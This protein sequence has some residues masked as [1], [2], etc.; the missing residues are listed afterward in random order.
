MHLYIWSYIHEWIVEIS[1]VKSVQTQAQSANFWLGPTFWEFDK[2]QQRANECARMSTL[3]SQLHQV[4]LWRVHDT[5]LGHIC[6]L[7]VQESSS[8]LGQDLQTPQM[9]GGRD[10]SI[11][12][13][14]KIF[15]KS[16]S[17]AIR[18]CQ[19]EA[20]FGWL[21]FLLTRTTPKISKVYEHFQQQGNNHPWLPLP[22]THRQLSSSQGKVAIQSLCSPLAWPGSTSLVST[23][24]SLEL[25][26]QSEVSPSRRHKF[27]GF[28][29]TRPPH[30]IRSRF[31][32]HTWPQN[33]EIDWCQSHQD[34][35]TVCVQD[36]FSAIICKISSHAS[37]S[38][39]SMYRKAAAFNTAA[40]G[41]KESTDDLRIFKCKVD[42]F[43]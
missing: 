31:Q 39:A 35:S 8:K 6:E 29:H 9:I 23:T 10:Q 14:T 32:K 5:K 27:V 15:M 19:S 36:S 13:G 22:S 4:S 24:P 18:I 7:W 38:F 37:R 11:M 1:E 2:L 3:C 17:V 12:I 21:F 40:W 25:V 42:E 30:W 33:N 16:L 41:S 34:V 28:L 26:M 43:H 20:F